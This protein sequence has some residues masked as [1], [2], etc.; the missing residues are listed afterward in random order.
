MQH[1]AGTK[2]YLQ[3]M[4]RR[5][6]E[7]ARKGDVHQ[8]QN[9]IEDDPFLMK[10][11]ALLGRETPLHIACMPVKIPESAEMDTALSSQNLSK[12]TK[13][14]C[15]TPLSDFSNPIMAQAAFLSTLVGVDVAEVATRAA[16]AALSALEDIKLKREFEILKERK[17]KIGTPHITVS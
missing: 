11:V 9:L 8:L 6:I 5:L 14:T 4:D 10:A 12:P 17:N 16:L 1:G 15:L 3:P 7:V 13:R 2:N